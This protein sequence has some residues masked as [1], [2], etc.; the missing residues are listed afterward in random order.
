M[1]KRPTGRESRRM[2][3]AESEAP[4]TVGTCCGAAL[5]TTQNGGDSGRQIP[6]KEPGMVQT[7]VFRGHEFRVD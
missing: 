4:L 3:G 5:L 6:Q 1:C 2:F 7:R